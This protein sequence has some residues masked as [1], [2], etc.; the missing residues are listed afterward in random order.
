MRSGGKPPERLRAHLSL[1]PVAEEGRKTKRSAR[2]IDSRFPAHS[3]QAHE[4]KLEIERRWI[5]IAQVEAAPLD[6][7]R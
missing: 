2:S 3:A 6:A 1:E 7:R 4:S 5:L